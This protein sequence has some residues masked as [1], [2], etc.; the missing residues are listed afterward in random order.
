MLSVKYLERSRQVAAGGRHVVFC[1][2]ISRRHTETER[3]RDVAE[4]TVSWEIS[5]VLSTRQRR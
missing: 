2:W 1:V 3:E 5:A 4:L